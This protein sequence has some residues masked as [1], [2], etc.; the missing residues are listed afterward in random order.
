MGRLRRSCC[1]GLWNWSGLASSGTSG[2]SSLLATGHTR[3]ISAISSSSELV[4]RML[5]AFVPRVHDSI[6]VIGLVSLPLVLVAGYLSYTWIERPLI[7]LLYK[8][9]ATEPVVSSVVR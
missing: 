4:S 2:S 7:G 8:R 3:S 5:L 1:S 9:R 6:L